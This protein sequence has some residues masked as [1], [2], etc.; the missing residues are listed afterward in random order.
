MTTWFLAAL[1]R[2][3]T[4]DAPDGVLPGDTPFGWFGFA[5]AVGDVDG[6][7]Y[8]DLILGTKWYVEDGAIALYPG[9]PGGLATA[10]SFRWRRPGAPRNFGHA[11]AVGDLDGDGADELIVSDHDEDVVYVYAG[12]APTDEP[13]A[14]LVGEASGDFFGYALATVDID[15]DGDQD[16]VVGAPQHDVTR[17]RVYL[18]EGGP[19]GIATT[20]RWTAD[21]T[22]QD[23]FAFHLGAAGDLN[24][25][26][27]G[28]F[29]VSAPH[30]GAAA[31]G[32]VSV[33]LGGVGG[34]VA[35]GQLL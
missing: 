2:A 32:A 6:D 30:F 16:L 8:R 14:V 31:T 5:S 20:P 1:A 28:D 22:Q 24:G 33:F 3:A 21:G 25:D 34:P 7:G 35:G 12:R 11:L 10:P 15:G 29:V 4:G 17:G 23:E 9:G 26:G 19:D 18:Y 27:F 13:I